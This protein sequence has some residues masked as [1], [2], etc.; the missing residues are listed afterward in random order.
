MCLSQNVPGFKA[1]D[2]S[3][4]HADFINFI[5]Y[6]NILMYCTLVKTRF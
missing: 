3:V 4:L 2:A 5:R 6:N 1:S